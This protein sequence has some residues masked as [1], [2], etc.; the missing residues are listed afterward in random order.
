MTAAAGGA[1]ERAFAVFLGL[2]RQARQ[3]ATA[4]QL[5]FTMVNDGQALFG[6]RHAALLIAGKV[7]ALT[8]IS[9]VE[10]NAPFVA[11]VERAAASL[12]SRGAEAGPVDPAE[13]DEQTVGEWQALSAA[14]ACWLPLNDRQG[15]TFGGLWLAR[16]QPFSEAELT[17]L[18]QLA[19][20]YAH[21]WLAL[22][23]GKPWRLRWPRRRIAM[24]LG[25]ALL[26]LLVPVR[27]AVLAPAEVV[28]L[29]GRVVAAP[30]DGV[31]AEILVKPNQRVEAG[32]LLARLDATTLKAQADVAER[33]LDVA[34]A[35][36]KA[37]TQR[38]F[39]DAQSNARLDLLAAR[40]EQKRAELDYARQ[41]LARSEIRAERAGIAV[42][43][44]AE[45][46]TG[47]PV[48]TGERL[49]QIADPNQAQL[50]MELPVGDAIAL[51]PGA[52][53]ALFLDSD[54][55]QRHVASLERAAYEAQLTAAGQLAY[56]LD[57]SFADSPPR[58]GLRGTAKLYGARAPLV[59]Y[60]LRKP[61]AALRQGLGV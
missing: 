23:P 38:A 56:R 1:V 33:S 7:Q 58:I 49:M 17:L 53:V 9:V 47:K 51:Q 42:F 24:V 34:E 12:H 14:H 57:A 13:L 22:R 52:E 40:V 25:A 46:W 44:D 30:L 19:E 48:Q 50:R 18:G 41:L 39:S 21:A 36:L 20:T 16:E 35:E 43:A 32:E 26:V 10:A 61:L 6:F 15:E 31:V 28:P 37:S 45:R 59:Y 11:F 27:Q 3:A 4:E 2:Q 29:G 8:G 5:G 60:L 55:L 54:P